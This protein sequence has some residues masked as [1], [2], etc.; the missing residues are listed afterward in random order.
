MID[1]FMYLMSAIPADLRP[2]VLLAIS[3]MPHLIKTLPHRHAID[4][5]I[6]LQVIRAPMDDQ[7]THS[8]MAAVDLSMLDK[9]VKATLFEDWSFMWKLMKKNPNVYPQLP[10]AVRANNMFIHLALQYDIYLIESM[11][12]GSMDKTEA[13]VG[14]K[15]YGGMIVVYLTEAQADKDV[16]MCALQNSN[17]IG[18][19]LEIVIYWRRD[20]FFD[21]SEQTL[22]QQEF[23]ANIVEMGACT[24]EKMDEKLKPLFE[25]S[26]YK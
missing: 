25:K 1:P 17:N 5:E 10:K 8:N 24:Q 26:K 20:L 3:E 7:Q 16:V 9:T 23:C 19:C 6:A 4:H 11:P 12:K 14:A 18:A 15:M 21:S 13:L 2:F 22:A